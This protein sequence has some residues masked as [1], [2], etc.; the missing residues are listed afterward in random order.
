MSQSTYE[1]MKLLNQVEVRKI[2]SF[3]F[4]FRIQPFV[5]EFFLLLFAWP[6][7]PTSVNI[8]SI[9]MTGLTNWTSLQPLTVTWTLLGPH[10]YLPTWVVLAIKVLKQNGCSN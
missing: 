6:W 1:T 4:P 3:K 8:N 9:F 10:S 2:L 7:Q 5:H